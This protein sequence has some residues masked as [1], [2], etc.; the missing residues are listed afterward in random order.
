VDVKELSGEVH[1]NIAQMILYEKCVIL[2][3]QIRHITSQRSE[4]FRNRSKLY[5]GSMFRKTR[6]IFFLT[7]VTLTLFIGCMKQEN[8][9]D[10]PEIGFLGYR[11][12]YETGAFPTKCILDISFHDGN[13]DIGLGEADTLPPYQPGGPYYYNLV[14]QYYEKQNGVFI[15]RDLPFPLSS[16]IPVLAPDDPGRAIKGTI[17]DTVLV[18][19][20]PVHDTIQMKLFIYDHALHKSNVIST[21]EIIL[22]RR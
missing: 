21:P 3:L 2:P 9:P 19:P 10:T 12:L 16:R 1:K 11:T 8:F 17:T 7:V 14:I 15:L 5:P 6:P 4:T 22:S 18:D 20:N 13:G